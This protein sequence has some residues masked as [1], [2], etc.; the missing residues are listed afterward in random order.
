MHYEFLDNSV[1]EGHPPQ[2]VAFGWNGEMTILDVKGMLDIERFRKINI[3]AQR[4]EEIYARKEP[5][6]GTQCRRFSSD[7]R[8]SFRSINFADQATASIYARLQHGK[9]TWRDAQGFAAARADP[10]AKAGLEAVAPIGPCVRHR[11]AGA[12]DRSG[13]DK[14]HTLG[15]W[16]EAAHVA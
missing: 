16:G 7:A 11:L 9:W 6:A 2:T 12:A 8:G 1:A 13:A 5:G 10:D 14:V 15:V 3:H 4:P